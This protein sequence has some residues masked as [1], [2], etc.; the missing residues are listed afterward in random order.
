LCALGLTLSMCT[1][2]G[3]ETD[4][5]VVDFNA[6]DCKGGEELSLA[7][8]VAR[9]RAALDMPANDYEG[10]HCYAW[11]INDGGTITIDV[12]NYGSGCGIE[13]SLADSVLDAEHVEL[14]IRNAACIVA[15]CGSCTYDLSFEV[16]GVALDAPVEVQVREAGCDGADDHVLRAVELPIDRE[17]EGML[18]R[19]TSGGFP[20]ECG[21][22][23]RPPCDN[24]VPYDGVGTCSDGCVEG[25][26]CV[27][28][29]LDDRDL[30]FTPCEEDADC[31]L[32][33]ESCQDGACRLR[34]TF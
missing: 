31:P 25:L 24:V 5:P 2:A 4:N 8:A 27:E 10:L 6:T 15:G 11:Q 28:R 14:G 30:C 26:V 1:S 16:K 29:A 18:C 33:I 17:R 34:E 22:P 32:D 12:I 19:Q 13:W 23:R 3:T 9:T 7:P 21:G 20:P